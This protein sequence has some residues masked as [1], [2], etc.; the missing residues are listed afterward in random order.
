MLV[1]GVFSKHFYFT[2]KY[3]WN[4]RIEISYKSNVPQLTEH[5]C[6][7]CRSFRRLAMNR[8]ILSVFAIMLLNCS[9]KQVQFELSNDPN[10]P[11]LISVSNVNYE[12]V[13][14]KYIDF[15]CVLSIYEQIDEGTNV[16]SA[17]WKDFLTVWVII[18]L[19]LIIFFVFFSSFVFSV[20]AIQCI[21]RRSICPNDQQYGCERVHFLSSRM[22]HVRTLSWS[23]QWTIS[24]SLPDKTWRLH[25]PEYENRPR[26]IPNALA[27]IQW[28]CINYTS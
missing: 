13:M 25:Y 21:T 10:Y 27:W 26:Q 18:V 15:S 19:I 20:G 6:W 8:F 4:L 16:S 1:P 5:H 17:I 9:A 2:W 12:L 7:K 14:N 3:Y 23:H 22:A 28:C 24:W 11:Q